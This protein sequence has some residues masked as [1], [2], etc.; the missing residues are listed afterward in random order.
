VR[1][2]TYASEATPVPHTPPFLTAPIVDLYNTIL[3]V[4]CDATA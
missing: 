4:R 3:R 2:A 1:L